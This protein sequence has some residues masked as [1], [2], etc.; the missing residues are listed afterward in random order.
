M[1]DQHKPQA[2]LNGW[3]EIAAYLGKSVRSV[4][5]WEATLGLPVHR[6]KTP[7][8]QIVYSERS[9][10]DDWRRRQEAPPTPEPEDPADPE[11]LP[12]V[13]APSARKPGAAASWRARL[14]LVAAGVAL[15]L[16]GI[17][18]GWW[19]SRPAPVAYSVEFAGRALHGLNQRGIV[20]W[21]FE[22]DRDVSPGGLKPRLVDLDGDGSTEWIVPVRSTVPGAVSDAILCFS[23]GG[24]LKWSVRPD[25]RLTYNGRMVGAP[26]FLQ[27]FE[28]A[29]N[30][31]RRVWGS[32]SSRL[33]GPSFIVEVQ[34]GGFS[35]MRYFQAGPIYSLR[36]WATLSGGYI[37]AGG[38]SQKHARPSIVLLR[39]LDSPAS[40]PFDPV[41]M[42]SRPSCAECPSGEPG[43]VF[44]F[45]RSEIATPAYPQTSVRQLDQ[46]GAAIV[47]VMRVGD[48]KTATVRLTPDFA[49]ASFTYTPNHWRAHREL[50]I[51][52]RL[53]HSEENCPDRLVSNTF[54]E[55]TPSEGWHDREIRVPP[56]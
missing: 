22:F 35:V 55:W 51:Q 48:V 16:I 34:A 11:S 54:R 1:H 17:V 10:I 38:Y 26:W 5:R 4:Q 50:E 41:G 31:P 6:I 27:D 8:G 39:D 36:H 23:Q 29:S 56:R 49:V 9:E 14:W 45:T 19:F 30:V 44:L 32:F 7:D 47:G 40:F 24:T 42:S 25:Q 46:V 37:V 2:P 20:V 12:E 52:G 21:S 53:D 33:D 28:V 18:S 43:R 3:K 15:L 13:S